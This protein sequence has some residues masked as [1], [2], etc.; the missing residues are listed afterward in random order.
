MDQRISIVKGD[1]TKSKCEAI[2][3]AANSSLLGG[4][5]IDGAIHLAAGPELLEECKTLNGCAVG[6]AKIT[7]GYNLDAKYVIHAVG[8]I[9]VGGH[10]DEREFLASSYRN[11]LRL[12][13]EKGVLS[14]AF[15]N[16]STGA[17]R[18][19]A[20]QAANIALTEVRKFLAKHSEPQEIIFVVFTE[21][22]YTLY[23]E[24]LESE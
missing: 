12:A 11:S 4:G 24:L 14:L 15:P 13:H 9:W 17:Y 8:P 3:N 23:K 5:G 20:R 18:F 1:I 21:D 22:N 19:P 2:V 10:S 16:I 7:S 6:D